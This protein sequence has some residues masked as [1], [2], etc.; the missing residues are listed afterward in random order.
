MTDE[1]HEAAV[2]MGRLNKSRSKSVERYWAK[3][4][5]TRRLDAI[6]GSGTRQSDIRFISS[7]LGDQVFDIEVKS[8]VRPSISLYEEAVKKALDGT[9]PVLGLEVRTPQGHP[10]ERYCIMSFEDF[11]EIVGAEPEED[12]EEA[13]LEYVRQGFPIVND[14]DEDVIAY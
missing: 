7:R 10:N 11:C 13:E 2:K 14:E 12:E 9:T 8:R 5:G 1:K 3:R 6:A 4:M